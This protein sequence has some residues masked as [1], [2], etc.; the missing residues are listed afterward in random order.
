MS[1]VIPARVDRKLVARI[2]EMISKGLYVSRSDAVR[3][4][5]RNLAISQDER[6]PFQSIYR[7]VAQIAAAMMRQS[8]GDN[9]GDVILFGSV[10]RGRATQDSDI[11]LLVLIE[12]GETS[13]TTR[14]IVELLYPIMLASDTV[15]TPVVYSRQE[16][17]RLFKEEYVFASEIIENGT[18][19]YGD[20]LHEIRDRETS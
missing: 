20:L 11:D 1:R 10:S 18:Q 9:L 19:I 15:I 14:S 12:S 6:E 3:D 16:F 17:L 7:V 8:L 4:A 5:I 13:T 2:D